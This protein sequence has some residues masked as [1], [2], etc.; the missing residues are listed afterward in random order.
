MGEE[1]WVRHILD[2]EYTDQ[3]NPILQSNML[4]KDC[5]NRGIVAQKLFAEKEL[6]KQYLLVY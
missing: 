4:I 2:I 6:F 5:K 1:P 3:P